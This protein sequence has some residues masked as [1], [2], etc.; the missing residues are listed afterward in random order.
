MRIALI[1]GAV[2]FG[3]LAVV[4]D[5]QSQAR[6]YQ[7]FFVSVG[8]GW[9]AAAS[10][11]DLHG[12]S[13]IPGANKSADIVANSLVA[14]GA[15]YGIRL[16][17]DD[18]RF[19]TVADID[20]AIQTV[21]SK[22]AAT[23][24]TNPLFVFYIASHGMSEGIAWSHFSIPGDFVYRGNPDD[25]NIDALSKSALYA[26][27]L[28]DELEKFKIPFLVIFD[29]C[30]DGQEKHFEPT[31]LSAKATRNLNEVGA[32]LR[33]M[34]EFRNTYPVLFSTVP[35]K[36][37]VTVTNPLVPD[38][39][40]A[41]APLARRFSLSVEP[42]LK[43]GLPISLSSFL[44]KMVS[45]QL[46]TLTAPAVT[47]SP[48]P[49][50][51]DAIFLLAAA[52]PHVMESLTGTGNH[53]NICCAPLPAEALASAVSNHFK[54]TL[55]ITGTKGEY[56]SSGGSTKFSSP[57]YKVS[58]IQRGAGD[59][60]I[61]FERNDTEFDASFATGSD[62]RFEA[63]EYPG[64]Q[65]WNMA[66]VGRPALEV[67]G[68]GRGCGEITGSFTVSSVQYNANGNITRFAATFLQLCDDS[69][70]PATGKIE[71]TSD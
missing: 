6:Q 3:C 44:S 18:Q 65:R 1:R 11:S 22:I 51:A 15:E 50:G 29:S 21:S 8:S 23:K 7:V 27:S 35:G 70:T 9:Y 37:V 54:G 33:V 64:A 43:K 25:L 17:S 47:R 40:V 53:M 49:R 31:V 2:A 26:G 19:V 30:S 52:K 63:K 34:N 45:A 39:V 42:S 58:V 71:L 20:K 16:T 48:V 59:I 4:S 61:Q 5:L 67:S 68:D 28:V 57:D 60:Q 41:I 13:R 24:P 62:K 56:I 46:D 38:S 36:S 14:G 10:G 55:S 12:F 32:V 69:A 66:D